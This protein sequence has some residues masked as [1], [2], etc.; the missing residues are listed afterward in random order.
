MPSSSASKGINIPPINILP[1]GNTLTFASSEA[2]KRRGRSG[3]LVAVEEVGG[4]QEDFLD[5]SAFPNLNAGW[6]NGKGQS[7]VSIYFSFVVIVSDPINAGS[8]V[9]TGAWVIHPVLICIGKLLVDSIPGMQQNLSWTIV[10]LSY[11]LVCD[12]VMNSQFHD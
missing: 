11:M 5:Q 12:I 7:A 2:A 3:S 1:S 4:G 9:T 10:N 8:L 6:V